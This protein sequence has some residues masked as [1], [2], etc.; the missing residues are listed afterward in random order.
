[1]PRPHPFAAADRP[2]VPPRAP[3]RLRACSPGLR[4]SQP[5]VWRAAPAGAAGWRGY[6][7]PCRAWRDSGVPPRPPAPRSSVPASARP[8]RCRP[9]PSAH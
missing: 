6:R 1:M 4:G 9:A 5:G 8:R 2:S 3:P 7:T